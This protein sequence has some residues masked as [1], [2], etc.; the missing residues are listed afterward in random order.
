M[1]KKAEITSLTFEDFR[2]EN[3]LTYWWATDFM[4][5]LGYDKFSSFRNAMDR[6]IKACISLNIKFDEHFISCQNPKTKKDDYKLT[7]FACYLTVMNGDVKKK[8][9]AAA[10]AY[11]IHQTRQ[12][13]LYLKGSEDIERVLIRDELKD[14]TKLLN[15]AAK[16]AGVTNYGKFA[17]AGYMGLYNMHTGQVKKAKGFDSN[18]NIP[19]ADYMGRTELAANLFRVTMTE[20]KLKKDNVTG[21]VN[22]ENTHFDVAKQ[23]RNFVVENVGITP[24][25]L[26]TERRLSELKSDIKKSAKK[27]TQIDQ[28]KLDIDLEST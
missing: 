7:R 27:L 24:E 22:A 18:S 15:A 9:V 6:A 21:Q 17:D 16:S 23:V 11:F 8:E 19:L 5:M 10:Q 14:G 13:E 3:G 28:E 12:F 1:D 26:K 25:E 20:E 4:A 2:N